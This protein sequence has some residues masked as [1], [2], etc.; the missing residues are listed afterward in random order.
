[1]RISDVRRL[2]AAFLILSVCV[3]LFTGCSALSPE[4]VAP[5]PFTFAQ[6]CDPQLGMG[7][8]EHDMATFNQAVDRIN[9]LQPDFVVICGDLVE[10]PGDQSYSDFNSIKSRLTVPVYC[11]PGNH[12][13]T[14]KP[15]ASSLAYYR[16][17][18]GEDYF[19]VRHTGYT[20]MVINTSLIKE[21]VAGESER[22]YEWMKETL[23]AAR[24]KGSP[25]IA[26]GHYPFYLQEPDE[27]DEYFNLPLAERKAL[28]DMF[29]NHGVVAFLS[30]HTHKTLMNEY[31]GML[32]VCGES[33]SVNFDK[34]P[35]GFRLWT[36]IPSTAL[37]HEFV[38]L[39]Q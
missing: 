11:A 25:V 15:S 36:V 29:R 4:K 31:D 34:R 6:L 24:K 21:E 7:G 12:D 37:R 18:M 27:K 39:E 30:G 32:L 10:F 2:K 14:G 17:K 9:A 13:V 26:V 1:M 38:P 8:Y 23:E 22:H 19:S 20:I 35:M 3:I 33:T 28:L 16:E 5:Q